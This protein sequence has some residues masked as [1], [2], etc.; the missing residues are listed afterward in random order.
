MKWDALI[1]AV[2]IALGRRKRVKVEAGKRESVE[3]KIKRAE[4]EIKRELRKTG[5]VKVKTA[6]GEEVL[7]PEFYGLAMRELVKKSKFKQAKGKWFYYP[8]YYPPEEY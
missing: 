2:V 8:P 1:L 6:E 7:I 5:V 4:R 3:E